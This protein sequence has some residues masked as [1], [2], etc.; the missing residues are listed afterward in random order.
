MKILELQGFEF[1][2]KNE[3][4]NLGKSYFFPNEGGCWLYLFKILGSLSEKTSLNPWTSDSHFFNPLTVYNL[5]YF[6]N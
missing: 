3:R 5:Q 2:F 1:A 6:F 4:S